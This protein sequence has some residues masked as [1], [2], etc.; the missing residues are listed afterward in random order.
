MLIHG[1][2]KLIYLNLLLGA[3]HLKLRTFWVSSHF[4][5]LFMFHDFTSLCNTNDSLHEGLI[6]TNTEI[7]VCIGSCCLRFLAV[8]FQLLLFSSRLLHLSGQVSG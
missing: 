3:C 8:H 5:S 2:Y 6:V 7:A 1:R 4:H